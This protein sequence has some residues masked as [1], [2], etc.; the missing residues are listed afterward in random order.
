MQ[1]IWNHY[2]PPDGLEEWMLG[3]YSFRG[4]GRNLFN[5]MMNTFGSRWFITSFGIRLVTFISVQQSKFPSITKKYMVLQG[6]LSVVNAAKQFYKI[7]WSE[8]NFNRFYE[9]V[10]TAEKHNIKLPELP[11]YLRL[12]I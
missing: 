5:R 12:Q 2:I 6:A 7:I 10:I 4:F 9:T 8:T 11:R 3:R 1:L